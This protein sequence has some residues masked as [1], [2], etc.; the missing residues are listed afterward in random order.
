MSHWKL[1][2]GT[3]IGKSVGGTHLSHRCY[4]VTRAFFDSNR[5]AIDR[6]GH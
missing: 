2:D 5:A 3:L 6:A 1:R 4:M